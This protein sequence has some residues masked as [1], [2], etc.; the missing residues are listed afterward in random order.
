MRKH[1]IIN[2]SLKGKKY[3]TG[4]DLRDWQR[5]SIKPQNIL[6]KYI[7]NI[8]KKENLLE[9]KKLVDLLLIESKEKIWKIVLDNI[10]NDHGYV[11]YEMYVE[12]LRKSLGM[13]YYIPEAYNKAKWKEFEK[14][15]LH[16]RK[17]HPIP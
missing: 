12:S 4:K 16:Y 9:Y 17:L 2:T 3:M 6:K 1:K 8:I 11:P 7:L 10:S 15:G 13:S 14:E 5:I